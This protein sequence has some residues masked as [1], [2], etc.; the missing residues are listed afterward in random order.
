VF[1]YLRTLWAQ[2]L[3]VRNAQ[4]ASHVTICRT[5]HSPDPWMRAPVAAPC[6]PGSGIHKHAQEASH[7]G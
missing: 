2:D 3:A 4:C 7:P 6:G 1:L 5:L